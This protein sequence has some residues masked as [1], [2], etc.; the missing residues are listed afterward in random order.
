MALHPNILA[1][2]ILWT[3]EPGGLKFIGSQTDHSRTYPCD[4]P[5]SELILL[6]LFQTMIQ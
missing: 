1:Q 5:G 4:T 2:R 3:E 6:I